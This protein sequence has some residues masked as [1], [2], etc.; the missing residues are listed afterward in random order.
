MTEEYS[1]FLFAEMSFVSSLV[2]I[3]KSSSYED[4]RIYGFVHHSVMCEFGM[5]I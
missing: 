5:F 1:K 3:F 2:F 4:R